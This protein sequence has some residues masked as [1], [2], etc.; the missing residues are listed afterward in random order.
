MHR[1]TVGCRLAGDFATALLPRDKHCV[2]SQLLTAVVL[3]EDLRDEEP[4]RD[5]RRAE[6]L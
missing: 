4:N 3:G 1:L 2:G 6:F 5:H